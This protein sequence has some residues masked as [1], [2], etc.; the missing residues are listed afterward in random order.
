MGKFNERIKLTSFSHGAGCACKL[1]LSDLSQVLDLLGPQAT[2]PDVLVGLDEADD[3][4]VVK[5]SDTDAMVL[6]LDFFTP[7]VDDP[8][9]WGQIAATN[10]AS[11]VYAMGG[12]PL[13]AL[14]IA[15]WPRET[16]PLELLADVL[17]GGRSVA[18]AGGFLVV[19]GHTVDDPEPKYGMVV[20]GRADPRRLMTID[21]AKPG[22][23]LVL[24]KPIGTGVITTAIKRDVAP[25][26]AVD[27][28]VASMTRLNDTA[29][30][31]LVAAGV[32]AC[33]DVT[34][35]GLLGHLHRMLKASGAA[36]TIDAPAVP[37]LTGVRELAESGNVPGGTVRNLDAVSDAVSW[38]G[39]SD[40]T[41]HLLSDAQTSGG[42]LAACAPDR[43]DELLGALS[44]ELACAV[45][46]TVTEGPPGTI[47]VTGDV[48]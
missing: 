29:S 14:N 26:A 3:A 20:V 11:D 19:G 28:A 33:T 43:L 34:G 39:A 10:A 44:G 38:N 23:V 36:G 37:L 12:R 35:F 15:A 13:V 9:V 41:R 40:L 17:R 7:L 25:E 42:L 8:F 27:A 24:T 45:V 48:A 5:I 21:A 16:I 22:D 6:T 46:G 47:T 18:E 31:A 4:A 2:H 30:S 1:G 32:S